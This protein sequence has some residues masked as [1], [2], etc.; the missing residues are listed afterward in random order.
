MDIDI[1][2]IMTANGMSIE[3]DK[4]IDFDSV[5]FNGN[6]I[7][8]TKPV[9]VIGTVKNVGGGAFVLEGEVKASFK[10][11][12]ARCLCDFDVDFPFEIYEKFVKNG[13]DE[14]VTLL[15]G[16][17]IDLSDVVLEHLYMN[18]PISFICKDTCKGLCQE[19]GQNLNEGSCNCE[20]DNIDPRMSALLKFKK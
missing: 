5:S 13:A 3:V 12:C 1:S 20:D 15:E 2:Q 18:L 19:C 6:D 16:N 10:T 4:N 17:K 9:S 8:F 7:T 14:F 11:A